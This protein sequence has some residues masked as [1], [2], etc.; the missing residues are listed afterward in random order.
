VDKNLWICSVKVICVLQTEADSKGDPETGT[1]VQSCVFLKS[2]EVLSGLALS[3][4][5]RLRNPVQ[6]KATQAEEQ[7]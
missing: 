1:A 6:D 5:D 3:R 2:G 4:R 7:H